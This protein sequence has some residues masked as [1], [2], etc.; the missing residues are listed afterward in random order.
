MIE[1]RLKKASFI[2]RQGTKKA[3]ILQEVTGEIFTYC[4]QPFG[5][6]R[7]EHQGDKSRKYDYYSIDLKTGLSFIWASKKI[8]LLANLNEKEVV[9]QYEKLIMRESYKEMVKEFGRLKEKYKN[10]ER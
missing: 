1:S 3:P 9:E 4:G 5:V 10:D 7:G 6:Y 8:D 2:V